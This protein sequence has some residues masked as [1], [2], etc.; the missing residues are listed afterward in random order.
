M[1]RAKVSSASP[2]TARS[3]PPCRSRKSLS[4]PTSG[5]PIRMRVRGDRRF[6]SRARC[7]L[8][9]LFHR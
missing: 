8:R 7:R 9:S 2:V 6:T 1:T 4:G 5:P 3:A